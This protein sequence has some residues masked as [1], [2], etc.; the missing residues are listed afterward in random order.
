MLIYLLL[1]EIMNK[2]FNFIRL[3]FL[4]L[5]F[6]QWIRSKNVASFIWRLQLLLWSVVVWCML[7]S[8]SFTN[9]WLFVVCEEFIKLST[10]KFILEVLTPDFELSKVNHI[11]ATMQN[12]TIPTKFE[13]GKI[14]LCDRI[15]VKSWMLITGIILSI[16]VFIGTFKI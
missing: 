1:A 11:N 5:F 16:G 7:V 13:V 10:D 12:M 4:Q 6:P 15:N 8:D 3:R 14:V 9:Q 2:L